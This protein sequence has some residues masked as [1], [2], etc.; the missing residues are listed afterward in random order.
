MLQ[1]EGLS[2]SRRAIRDGRRHSRQGR[3]SRYRR[4]SETTRGL[5]L[6]ERAL[7]AINRSDW[8]EAE[9]LINPALEIIGDGQFDGYWT[10][11]LVYAGAS[12]V[13]AHRGEVT[14][15]REYAAR[16][17]RL[18]PL[19]TYALPV[20]SVQALI[21]LGRADL[22]LGDRGGVRACPEAGARNPSATA[23]PGLTAPSSGRPACSRRR[24][25][26]TG[27]GIV[28]D[29]GRVSRLLPLLATHLTLKEISERLYVSRNTVKTQAAAVYRKFGVTSRARPS[30]VS[31]NWTSSPTGHCRTRGW[32]MGLRRM[33][34]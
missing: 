32:S 14:V 16:A 11:A 25:D 13:S 19:L 15:A 21:E 27:R 28:A 17:A 8:S 33:G 10:S 23:R 12:R 6:A 5:L 34:S 4:R 20:V 30:T 18:R 1:M 29:H 2:Y 22:T 31:T 7:A 9:T 24:R 3:R 26:P